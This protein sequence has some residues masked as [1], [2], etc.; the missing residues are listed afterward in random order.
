MKVVYR[1]GTIKCN[2]EETQEIHRKFRKIVTMNKELHTR[3]DVAR[4]YVYQK[5]GKCLISCKGCVRKKRTT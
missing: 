5:G 2:K 4:I 1:A 3:R